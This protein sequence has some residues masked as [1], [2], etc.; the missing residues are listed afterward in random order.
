[1]IVRDWRAPTLMDIQGGR[2]SPQQRQSFSRRIPL[3]IFLQNVTIFRHFF[4]SK[5]SRKILN[6]D[7]MKDSHDFLKG[8]KV[9]AKV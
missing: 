4:L 5:W 2:R 7:L 9:R 8:R 3:G 1:M 6:C